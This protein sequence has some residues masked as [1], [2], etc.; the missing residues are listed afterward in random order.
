MAK[1][2]KI[3]NFDGW[4]STKTSEISCFLRFEGTPNFKKKTFLGGWGTSKIQKIHVFFTG[5]GNPK[6]SQK[7]KFMLGGR[8]GKN[9]KKIRKVVKA[10]FLK[11]NVF[12]E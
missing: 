12:W 6:N 10:E 5:M 7:L 9:Q 4:E 8:V 11:T 3:D 1:I 2:R